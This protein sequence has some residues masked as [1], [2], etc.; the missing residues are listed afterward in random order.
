MADTNGLYI[1]AG[2][3]TFDFD[4]ETR[5]SFE[6]SFSVSQNSTYDT[7]G[8][9]FRITGGYQLTDMVALEATYNSYG[10]VKYSDGRGDIMSPTA[11]TLNANLGYSLSSGIRPFIVAGLGRIT[12]NQKEQRISS[13]ES[14]GSFHWGLG[15]EYAPAAIENVSFKAAYESDTATLVYL[16]PFAKSET[17]LTYS[18]F[19]LGLS[20]KLAGL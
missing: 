4:A 14:G 10:T 7:E 11:M 6:P 18:S 9:T 17:D 19:Y 8:N 15:L 2:A 20:Y 13:E 5:S 1:S 16:S 3:G 12:L